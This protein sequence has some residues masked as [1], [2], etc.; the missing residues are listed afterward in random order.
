MHSVTVRI[1]AT[2]ITSVAKPEA[3]EKEMLDT[4][5]MLTET[6]KVSPVITKPQVL[7]I[8]IQIR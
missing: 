3:I 4:V 1:E 8:N 5:Q 2:F 6:L 7:I